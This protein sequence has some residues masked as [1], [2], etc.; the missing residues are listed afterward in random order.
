LNVTR[1]KLWARHQ[2]AGRV[3]YTNEKCTAAKF[4]CGCGKWHQVS[5]PSRYTTL[6]I[7]DAAL[8]AMRRAVVDGCPKRKV[9][10]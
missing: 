7:E 6:T 2:R 3:R 10:V 4:L 8:N 5:K 9:V 1:L